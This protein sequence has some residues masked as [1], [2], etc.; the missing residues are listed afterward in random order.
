ME[1]DCRAVGVER[2]RGGV[3]GV[4]RKIGCQEYILRIPPP[5]NEAETNHFL[6][7]EFR[8]DRCR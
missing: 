3:E 6:E 2:G 5:K 7:S 8:D 1:R 4:E